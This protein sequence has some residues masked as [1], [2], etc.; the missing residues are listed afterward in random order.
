[1]YDTRD[2]AVDPGAGQYLSLNGQLA[3]LRIGS[4]V[5]FVKSFFT[6]QAFRTVP[7]TNRIVLAGSA[8]LGIASGFRRDVGGRAVRRVRENPRIPL[9]SARRHR[10]R[11][12]VQGFHPRNRGP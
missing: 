11:Q 12:M 9:Q 1:M 8:R 10:R 4:E 2:D 3:A 6:A 7:R 5:G